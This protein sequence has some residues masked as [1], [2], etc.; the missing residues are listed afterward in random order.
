MLQ[1]PFKGKTAEDKRAEG[2]RFSLVPEQDRGHL[3]SF[4]SGPT[5]LLHGNRALLEKAP[6]VLIRV[7]QEA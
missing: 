5:A 1:T 3:E 2:L 6:G 7:N 4:L